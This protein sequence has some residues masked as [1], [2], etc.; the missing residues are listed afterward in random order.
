MARHDQPAGTEPS[1]ITA[2]RENLSRYAL[3]GASQWPT[4]VAFDLMGLDEEGNATGGGAQV[5]RDC[6]ATVAALALAYLNGAPLPRNP[7]HGAWKAVIEVGPAT[8]NDLV[9]ATEVLYDTFCAQCEL[10]I[11]GNHIAS[12]NGRCYISGPRQGRDCFCSEIERL[13]YV[14][15]GDGA[16]GELEDRR[17]D[18]YVEHVAGAELECQACEGPIH[19]GEPY[20][21][22]VGKRPRW[23]ICCRCTFVY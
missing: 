15:P 5:C 18:R 11:Q 3:S 13:C 16:G 10:L 12:C 1:A 9:A 7:E 19:R 23:I 20:C 21:E 6:I 8:A 17:G 22:L 2:A 4:A 14:R